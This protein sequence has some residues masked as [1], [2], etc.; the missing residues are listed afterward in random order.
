MSARMI[1]LC[2]DG[3]DGRMLD[4]YSADGS[5]PNLAALRRRG[6]ARPLSAPPGST[7]DS[8]WASFQY[9]LPLAEHG[10]YH[11]QTP[12]KNNRL[13]PAHQYEDLPIFWENLSSQGQQVAILDVPKC[14]APRTLNGIQIIDWLTHGE[15]FFAPISF[16]PS[17]MGE[18]LQKFGSRQSH[19]CSYVEWP[20]GAHECQSVVSRVS[21]EI[22]I[23]RAAG[24]HYLNSRPWDLFCLGFSQLHCVNH[25]YWDMDDI[26]S[27][28]ELRIRCYP[29]FAILHAVDEAIAAL[30]ACAGASAQCIVFAPTDW[31][32]SGSLDHLMPECVARVNSNLCRTFNSRPSFRLP[33][34]KPRSWP[35]T[36][37]P[38][39]DNCLALRVAAAGER[40]LFRSA[41]SASPAESLLDAIEEQFAELRDPD[42]GQKL[43]FCI[44]RPSLDHEGRGARNLPDLLIKYPSGH[45]PN[46]IESASIGRI[47][48]QS[49]SWRKGN[50][51]DGGFIFA[52]GQG[53]REGL[54][55][56]QEIADIGKL[57]QR[58][59]INESM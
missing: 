53:A 23:K 28:D 39:N 37:L 16:P 29:M 58:L 18:V 48:K 3:A 32:R 55:D 54:A 36:I 51:R 31:Q 46:A 50:H 14:R 52:S 12:Q 5:L 30:I 13:G 41:S 21:R 44:T 33:F 25:Q 26:P 45:F 8:L 34:T 10:R 11:D 20:G 15:Y 24:L 7:D 38:F 35:C 49:P 2:L 9:L 4:R 42:D 1:M 59:L 22:A 56:V 27:M 19:P 17:L 6:S 47:D 43:A 57:A 40:K